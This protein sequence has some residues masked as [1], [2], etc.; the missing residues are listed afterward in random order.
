M[1][2]PQQL[3]R[4]TLAEY[5]E[6]EGA[7]A[8]KS[9]FHNGE[10]H[11]MAGG[12]P[13]HSRISANCTYALTNAFDELGCDIY[14]SNLM[15]Q[16]EKLN[17]V[18]YPDASVV[19]GT[20]EH[21]PQ[22]PNLVRNPSLILEVISKGTGKYDRGSNFFNYQLIPSLRTYVLVE[23]NE[24]RVYVGHKSEDGGWTFYDYFGLEA[25]VEL[26]PFG[27]SVPMTAIYKRVVF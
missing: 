16:V 7:A 6:M 26:A 23:Q 22:A 24:P 2:H 9:E 21:D 3:H 17:T 20:I 4:L 13:M 19:C 14:E 18:L 15:V 25:V 12:P 5:L 11:A 10:V 27:V 1:G 8:Y